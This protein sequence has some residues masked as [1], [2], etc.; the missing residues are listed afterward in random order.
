M[1]HAFIGVVG[2][3]KDF[4]ANALKSEGFIRI[5]F[6]DE[7]LDMASDLV[8]YDVRGN[9]EED[10]AWFKAMPVGV[11]RPGNPLHANI[12]SAQMVRL[13]KEHPEIMTGRRLLT[14]LGTEVMRKRDQD[15]WIK[16]FVTKATKALAEGHGVSIA[17]CR[18]RNEIEAV[19]R[20]CPTT[21]FTFCNFK[22]PRYDPKLNH[23][24]ERLAQALLALGL[25]DGQVITNDHFDLAFKVLS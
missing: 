18:F 6:K 2:G 15:Y 19:R 17:D 13:L 7:L 22:S 12:I 25:T 3:G 20:T 24:S 10:Y 1:I 21:L 9:C 8:G 4:R 14:R 16:T 11:R 5:N 23:V